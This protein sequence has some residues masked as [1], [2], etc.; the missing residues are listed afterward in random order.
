MSHDADEICLCVA[1]HR[2]PP[3]E[4]FEHHVWPSGMG[5]PDTADNRVFVCPTTHANVHELLRMMVKAGPLTYRQCQTIQPRPVS[6]YAYDLAALGY[7]RWLAAQ[8]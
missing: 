6:R 4:Y 2:P 5:G 8:T 1:E 3:L 7:E